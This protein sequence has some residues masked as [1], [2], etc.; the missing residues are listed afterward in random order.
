MAVEETRA[1]GEKL[2]HGRQSPPYSSLTSDQ[3]ASDRSERRGALLALAGLVLLAVFLRF[4][5]LGEWNFQATEI[6]TLR[7]S[8]SPQFGNPRPLMYLLNYYVLRPLFP[9]DEFTM[10][11]FPAIFGVLAIPAMYFV[12]RR[13]V[14]VRAALFAALL[15]VFSPLH[16]S[17]SQL[18]RY[19]SLVFLLCAIYPYALYVGV[20]DRSRGMLALGIV[21]GILAV[22]A[23]PVSVLPLGGM[24]FY[25]AAR[26]RREQW[27]ALWAR[28][29]V[30]WSAAI[31]LLI[32]GVLMVR[33][34]PLLSSWVEQHDRNPGYGQFLLRPQAPPGLKQV[35]ILTG[36][37]ESLTVPLALSAAVGVY[38]L[39]QRQRAAGLYLLSVAVFP[40]A[41]L[42][43]VSLRTATSLYYLLPSVPVFFLAAGVFLDRISELNSRVPRWLLPTVMV[44]TILGVNA[45]LLI[46]DYRDGRRYDFRGVAAWLRT[47]L[48]PGDIVYSD[49][50]LVMAHYLPE[51]PVE[52]LR[53]NPVPLQ[54]S[55]AALQKARGGSSLW[56]VAPAPSHPMRTNL[57]NGGLIGWIYQ[58]CRLQ[59]TIGVGRIDFRQQYLQVY[60]CPT[61]AAPG[62][63]STAL[64]RGSP[65]P[66]L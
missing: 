19:W 33:L 58:H 34:V 40:I 26:M 39:W 45:P 42:I 22:L 31:A 9:L 24:A 1:R 53:P 27:R 44:L 56:V 10:R 6:F 30:Q 18:A 61:A 51:R 25:V 17:Y 59:K 50:P 41:F 28:K 47:R 2:R 21:S 52:H 20:R 38:F 36:Y 35:I 65:A 62:G 29:S 46:S 16:V 23:H 43:L 5:K 12:A 64:L 13:L 11:L 49:Q 4:W 7:D 60:N 3:P 37:L 32:I 57:E 8:H 55:F 15:L 54:E 48:A 63:S 14:G 66:V